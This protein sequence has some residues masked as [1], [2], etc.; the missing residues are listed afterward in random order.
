MHKYR[1]YDVDLDGKRHD[2]NKII[3]VA[4]MPEVGYYGDVINGSTILKELFNIFGFNKYTNMYK[5]RLVNDGSWNVFYE[6]SVAAAITP[7]T[8]GFSVIWYLQLAI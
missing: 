1:I 8:H 2:T 5:L 6:N 4:T 7:T 3:S